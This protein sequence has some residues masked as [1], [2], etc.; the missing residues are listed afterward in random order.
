M[1][2][3]DDGVHVVDVVWEKVSVWEVVGVEVCELVREGYFLH[4][5]EKHIV[6]N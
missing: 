4:T 5:K 1:V 2:G 6:I 3:V